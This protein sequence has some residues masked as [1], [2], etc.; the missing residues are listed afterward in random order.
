[1][2]APFTTV[3]FLGVFL[4]YNAAIWPIQI[5][6]LG[7]GL[8]VV[9][10]LLARHQRAALLIPSVLAL[11]WALNG[12]GYHFLFFSRI[13]P[14]AKVFAAAFVLQAMLF[15]AAAHAPGDLT[16]RVRCDLGSAAGLSL[17]AYAL[18]IYPLLGYLAG[19]GLMAGPMFGVAPCPTTIFTLGLL[20][21]ARGKWVVWLSV[22][23][24]LWSIVGLTAAL[25]LGIPEDF[26]LPVAGAGLV[27]ALAIA[28]IATG[29]AAHP[30]TP[31][32]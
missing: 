19:H 21:S 32:S 12:I 29:R 14:I 31:A 1:M 4:A 11:M 9:F 13:N 5:L 6:T 22:I 24:V 17:V 16:F 2:T 26:G 10:A 3:Q 7:L 28:K 18:M 8:S 20:L 30:M 25:Q 15:A 27:I 23:P